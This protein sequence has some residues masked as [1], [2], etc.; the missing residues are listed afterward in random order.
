MTHR[1][2]SGTAAPA[3]SPAM[4]TL[5][6]LDAGVP[7]ELAGRRMTG[8]LL[9]R[10][11]IDSD[12]SPTVSFNSEDLVVVN[13][14]TYRFAGITMSRRRGE[15][16]RTS[17]WRF[18]IRTNRDGTWSSKEPTEAAR[19]KIEHW[20]RVTAT[21]LHETYHEIF[22]SAH[23]IKAE[24]WATVARNLRDAA[25]ILDRFSDVATQLQ[26]PGAT[27]RTAGPEDPERIAWPAL[28]DTGIPHSALIQ[29]DRPAK[30]VGLATSADGEP[31]AYLAHVR[32][33]HRIGASDSPLAVPIELAIDAAAWEAGTAQNPLAG[34]TRDPAQ[35][36]A[37]TDN[38]R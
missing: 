14:V 6:S 2:T 27:I 8:Q 20:A 28:R 17:M 11:G 22:S 29:G 16:Q 4:N 10:F 25:E 35:H 1:A 34:A 30:V 7:V 21:Q 33:P 18:L 37:N 26:D 31:L 3:G 5:E 19:T 23:H 13:G 9:A 38:S 36:Q 32:R 24:T 15:F 12:T